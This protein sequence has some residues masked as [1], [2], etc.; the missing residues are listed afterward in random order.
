MAITISAVTANAFTVVV[1]H[2][3][4]LIFQGEKQLK[5]V[6]F[7]TAPAIPIMWFYFFVHQMGPYL[8]AQLKKLKKPAKEGNK[9]G[10]EVVV[11]V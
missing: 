8:P 10:Q 9:T 5:T 2:L 4:M 6:N 7:R 3:S 1:T 11:N